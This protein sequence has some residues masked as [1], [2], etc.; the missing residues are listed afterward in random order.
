M[1]LVF[2]HVGL[3]GRQLQNLMAERLWVPSYEGM[4]TAAAAR[5]RECHG[6]IGRQQGA[7]LALVSRLATA[8]SSRGQAWG[9]AFD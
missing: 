5:R 4:A 6:V 7:L 8:L 9:P 3:D 2:G 1:Q